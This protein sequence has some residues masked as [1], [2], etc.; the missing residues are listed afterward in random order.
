[1]GLDQPQEG[2]K[3][4]GAGDAIKN[5]S[6]HCE[7]SLPKVLSWNRLIKIKATKH[8]SL[9][10]PFIK[11]PAATDATI[12]TGAHLLLRNLLVTFDR[13]AQDEKDERLWLFRLLALRSTFAV[14]C[15]HFPVATGAQCRQ[16][17]PV[18]SEVR[19][20]FVLLL[21]SR[22]GFLTHVHKCD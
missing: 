10:R 15:M 20:Y 13:T 1:M 9:F 21:P 19:T 6:S 3:V 4:D 11:T 12:I 5:R 14:P 7:R 8:M 16:S 2:H 18:S 22:R 17:R